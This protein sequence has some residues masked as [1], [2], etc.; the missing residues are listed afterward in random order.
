MLE[1]PAATRRDVIHGRLLLGHD[2]VY[3]IEQRS[4][5]GRDPA[6]SYPAVMRRYLRSHSGQV[7]FFTLVTH[8]RRQILTTERGRKSLREAI[9]CVRRDHPFEI[10]AIVLLPDH[11]HAVL[12]LPRGDRNYS[13]RWRLIKSQFTQRWRESGGTEGDLSKSR[14]QKGER[15][16]WQRRFYEHTCRDEDDL[17]R[18]VDYVHVNPLKHGLVRKVHEWPWSSFHRYVTLGEYPQHWGSANDW[19]GDEFLD[20]E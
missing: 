2:P 11:L 20:A 10:T 14:Q 4:R 5:L 9:Q 13:T 1:A 6:I 12:E 7:Y 16:I 19:Y 18:C 3:G 15:G 17:K 8:E